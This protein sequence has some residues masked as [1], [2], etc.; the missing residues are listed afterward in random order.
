[1]KRITVILIS[2]LILFACVNAVS[3]GHVDVTTSDT[4]YFYSLNSLAANYGYDAAVS[5]DGTPYYLNYNDYDKLAEF[6]TS[7]AIGFLNQ[8]QETST[9]QDVKM[10]N[11]RVANIE[12]P[13]Y[14]IGDIEMP[15]D[16]DF[17]FDYKIGTVGLNKN[18]HIITNLYL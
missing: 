11:L 3:A 2:I 15:V 10:G 1:M 6:S 4:F 9:V 14:D 5:V 16:K 12:I 18:A 8:Y 7:F 13:G 17:G